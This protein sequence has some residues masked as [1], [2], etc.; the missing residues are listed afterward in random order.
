VN[1]SAPCPVV[2]GIVNADFGIVNA[3]FGIV[4]AD[5]GEVRKVFT[6]ERLS[7]ILADDG[8]RGSWS[9]SPLGRRL[10]PGGEQTCLRED[11]SLHRVSS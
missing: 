9:S 7:R 6:F 5:F 1:S 3:H 2:F 10:V 8:R 11:F 4:N